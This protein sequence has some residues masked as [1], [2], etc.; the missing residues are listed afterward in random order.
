M[1]EEIDKFR[2][3]YFH[4]KLKERKLLLIQTSFRFQFLWYVEKWAGSYYIACEY[5][6][7]KVPSDPSQISIKTTT[8]LKKDM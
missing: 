5:H 6:Y 4:F 2:Q 3:H 1:F 7:N 8:F